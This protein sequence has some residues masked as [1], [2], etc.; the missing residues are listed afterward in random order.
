MSTSEGRCEIEAAKLRLAAAKKQ[1][2]SAQNLMSSAEEMY[3]DAKKA[4]DNANKNK[5]MVQLQLDASEK[6]MKAAEKRL[7][8]AETRWEV[9]DIDGLNLPKNEGSKK[10]RRKVSPSPTDNDNNN[11]SASGNNNGTSRTSNQKNNNNSASA[12]NSKTTSTTAGQPNSRNGNAARSSNSNSSAADTNDVDQIVFEVQGCGV[13]EVNGSYSRHIKTYEGSPV[14][15]NSRTYNNE[16]VT[17]VIFC[18]ASGGAGSNIDNK[19]WYIGVSGKMT[20]FYRSLRAVGAG[21]N[22]SSVV[23][24]PMNSNEWVC[25][26]KGIMPLPRLEKV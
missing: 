25:K 7:A 21:P 10:K 18:R 5:G 23:L 6:E 13:S 3:I 9:I 20:Y 2:S 16:S 15:K 14:Y 19:Y 17:F 4:M 26:D 11:N 12:G 24:P 1:V 22:A 8:E